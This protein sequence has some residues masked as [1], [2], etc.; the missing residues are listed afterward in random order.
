MFWIFSSIYFL[1]IVNLVASQD[2]PYSGTCNG[3]DFSGP[4][5]MRFELSSN[6]WASSRSGKQE[7]GGM[8]WIM[9][10][11]EN[12]FKAWNKSL[13]ADEEFPVVGVLSTGPQQ[14]LH[15]DHRSR[16][17]AG[18]LPVQ[19]SR[20]PEQLGSRLDITG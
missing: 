7:R 11:T 18:A 13:A 9:P 16:Y 17:D 1:L 20:I 2:D 5:T 14:Y 3:G 12:T 6:R 8:L 15:C 4:A 10:V 19:L